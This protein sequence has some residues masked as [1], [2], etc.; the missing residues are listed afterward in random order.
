MLS[1]KEQIIRK[2]LKLL[3]FVDFH[4]ANSQELNI[5]NYHFVFWDKK[6]KI[7]VYHFSISLSKIAPKMHFKESE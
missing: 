7:N 3:Y 1:N 2:V 4:S 6:K 5:I